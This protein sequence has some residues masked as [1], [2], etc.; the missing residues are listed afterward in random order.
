MQNDQLSP[1]NPWGALR[2]TY[3]LMRPNAFDLFCLGAS[4]VVKVPAKLQINPKIRG[5]AKE[6]GKP[7]SRTWR[8]AAPTADYL[9]Y[10]LKGHVD[11]CR[12][13]LLRNAQREQKL[14]Q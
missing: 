5:C 14:L 2:G 11:R 4:G 10:A 7:Q 8:N 1:Q 13:M 3:D 9:V 6:P 12:Q